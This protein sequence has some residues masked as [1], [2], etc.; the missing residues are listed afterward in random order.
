MKLKAALLSL[1]LI[2]P[3]QAQ[4]TTRD[5]QWVVDHQSNFGEWTSACD[6]RDDDENEQRCYIRYVEV[7]ARQPM[8]GATFLFVT[9]PQPGQIEFELS[10]ERGT[11]FG[12]KPLALFNADTA[13]WTHDPRECHRG[14]RCTFTGSEAEELAARLSEGGELQFDFTDNHDRAWELRWDATGFANAFSDFQTELAAR[15]L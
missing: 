2:T 11:D 12:D 14:T 15:N 7:Y 10:F 1:L 5:W 4:N 13:T 6:H 8:F 3:A 9:S